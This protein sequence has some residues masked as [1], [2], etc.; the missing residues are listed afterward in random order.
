MVFNPWLVLVLGIVIGSV[1]TV[2]IR[3][4]FTGSGTLYINYSEPEKVSYRI[5]IDDLE[6]IDSKKMFLLKIEDI[7]DDFRDINM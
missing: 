6:E 4:I 2:L 1:M 3:G 5:E 7:T